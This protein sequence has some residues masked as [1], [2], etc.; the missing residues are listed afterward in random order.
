MKSSIKIDPFIDMGLSVKWATCNLGSYSPE[1]IGNYYAWGEVKTKTEFSWHSY[2]WSKD[3]ND[4]QTK[5][6]TKSEFGIVDNRI[7]LERTDDVAFMLFKGKCRIPSLQEW[8]EL[9]ENCKWH[10]GCLN[11]INGYLITPLEILVNLECIGR[12]LL[13]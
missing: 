10:F 6:N 8:N 13:T 5:Y 1:G 11:N 12:H 3:E 7:T 2:Q 9:F 4:T